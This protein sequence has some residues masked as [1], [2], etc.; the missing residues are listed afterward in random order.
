MS[1]TMNLN[2]RIS[3]VLKDHVNHE[4]GEGT[5]ENVSEY[6]RDLIRRDKQKADE[7][8]FIT[9]KA[10]LQQAFARPEEEFVA[11]TAHDIIGPPGKS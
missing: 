5:Y 9:L 10:E 6:I 11:L 7:R 1:D 4:V 8:S 3:G 2:V